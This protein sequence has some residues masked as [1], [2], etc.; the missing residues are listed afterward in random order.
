M[1]KILLS[2]MAIAIS[3]LVLTSCSKNNDPYVPPTPEPTPTPT[4]EPTD[5]E[6][7]NESFQTYVGGTIAPNQDWG[8]DASKVAAA[9]GLTRGD[10]IK[11]F[12]EDIYDMKYKKEYYDELEQCLPE[13]TTPVEGN[14]KYKNFEFEA[15]RKFRMNFVFSWTLAKNMEFGYYFYDPNN[16]GVASRVEVPI[17][18]DFSTEF[19]ANV[20]CHWS[21]DGGGQWQLYPHNYGYQIWTKMGATDLEARLMTLK[22]EPNP[23]LD[24]GDIPE[25]YHVGFYT[26]INNQKYY[27]NR[28]LN[29]DEKDSYF[30]AVDNETGMFENVF[31]VGMEDLDASDNDNDCNDIMIS[32]KK[33]IDEGCPT[34]IVP[35]KEPISKPVYRIIGEDI[36]A[37][38][39]SDFDFNDI[40]LD[41]QLTDKGANC[42]LQAAGGQ[43]PVRINKNDDLETHKLFKVDVKT[44]VNTNAP[45]KGLPG[46][47]GLDPVEFTIE[48]NF[49][50]VLD[51]PIQVYKNGQWIDFYADKG[52]PACKIL[53]DDPNFVWPKERESLKDKYTKFTDWV[54]DPTVKWY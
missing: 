54:K 16:G 51:V 8:F 26:V 19:D 21:S 44:M 34:L 11:P 27:T 39:S 42:K 15:H 4:P 9:R 36:S 47:D 31:I 35:K 53:V 43:L 40:V 25:G 29:K 28:Y 24:K 2:T 18:K 33:K 38:T 32:I 5:V 23:E 50:S 6:K 20:Y 3:A 10:E 1:R 14:G 37:E 45:E 49:K 30:V 46:V 48:G 22:S 13:K 7:Y 17:T 52:G 41:V 12:V